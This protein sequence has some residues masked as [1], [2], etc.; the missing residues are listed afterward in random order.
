MPSRGQELAA[1][2]Y[3]AAPEPSLGSTVRRMP[4][5]STRLQPNGITHGTTRS[6]ADW[7]SQLS[8][9]L[10]PAGSRSFPESPDDTTFARNRHQPA[11]NPAPYRMPPPPPSTRN[12]PRTALC[13]KLEPRSLTQF[14]V[15]L[16]SPHSLLAPTRYWRLPSLRS[17]KGH[18]RLRGWGEQTCDRCSLSRDA[19]LGRLHPVTRTERTREPGND[20]GHRY[21]QDRR[22]TRPG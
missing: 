10:P 19:F 12:R 1:L 22:M 5:R 14:V 7:S 16:G 4:G 2:G 17:H 15:A 3:L 21:R 6:A 20:A 13:H 18:V 11:C 9:S 8:R